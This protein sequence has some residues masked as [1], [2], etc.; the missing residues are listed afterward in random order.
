LESPLPLATGE[1]C[2]LALIEAAGGFLVD[3]LDAG[4]EAIAFADHVL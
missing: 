1:E 2:D 4:V 3:A